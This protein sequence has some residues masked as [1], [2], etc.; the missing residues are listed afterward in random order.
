LPLPGIR[1]PRW[2]VSR[3]G[4]GVLY[5]M[6]V[7]MLFPFVDSLCLRVGQLTPDAEGPTRLFFALK[8]DL[9]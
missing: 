6:T 2:T 3:D 1:V 9:P 4:R 8:R 7:W 5:A